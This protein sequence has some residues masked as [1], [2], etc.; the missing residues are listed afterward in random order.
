MISAHSVNATNGQK[1]TKSQ[2]TRARLEYIKQIHWELVSETF[3]GKAALRLAHEEAAYG[4]YT[5]RCLIGGNI[6]IRCL[7][8][9][10]NN[11]VIGSFAHVSAEG[12]QRLDNAAHCQSV[13]CCCYNTP[14]VS[15]QDYLLHTCHSSQPQNRNVIAGCQSGDLDELQP[16]GSRTLSYLWNT[17]CCKD[18][19]RRNC[20]FPRDLFPSLGHMNR[21]HLLTACI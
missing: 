16:G 11:G 17:F 5:P 13:N 19:H 12:V 14:H 7:S 6:S 4:S 1:C 10:Y 18:N 21:N 3:Q 2:M 9:G 20:C 15:L 8:R